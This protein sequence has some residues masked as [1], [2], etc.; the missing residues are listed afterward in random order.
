MKHHAIFV[1]L[2]T[3][4]FS[5]T[6]ASLKPSV[7]SNPQQSPSI[8]FIPASGSDAILDD[9]ALVPLRKFAIHNNTHRNLNFDVS[10]GSYKVS[11][12]PKEYYLPRNCTSTVIRVKVGNSTGHIRVKETYRYAFYVASNGGVTCKE[13]K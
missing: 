12:V 2:L 6:S 5:C 3:I 8:S 11:N 7:S 1:F 4:L 13:Y 9:R 10:Y